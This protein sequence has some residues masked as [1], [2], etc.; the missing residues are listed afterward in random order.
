MKTTDMKTAPAQGLEALASPAGLGETLASGAP[1]KGRLSLI[2]STLQAIG[3]IP[4]GAVLSIHPVDSAGKGSSGPV[5]ILADGEIVATLSGRGLAYAVLARLQGLPAPVDFRDLSKGERENF[6]G[7]I[8]SLI[9]SPFPYGPDKL[10][11]A[12]P[13]K[14]ER[15]VLQQNRKRCDSGAELRARRELL[16]EPGLLPVYAFPGMAGNDSAV[17]FYS[18]RVASIRSH[19]R[20]FLAEAWGLPEPLLEREGVHA[21]RVPMSGG[22]QALFRSIGAGEMECIASVRAPDASRGEALAILAEK[23]LANGFVESLRGE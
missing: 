20:A 8:R 19:Q 22:T 3:E 12:L 6:R 7:L 1:P 17:P 4:P 15:G 10:P 11:L 18:A 2:E 16:R 14:R 21:M 5:D 23:A 13:I 9:R